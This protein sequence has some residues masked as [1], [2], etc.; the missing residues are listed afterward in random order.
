MQK[1]SGETELAQKR[2]MI[3]THVHEF[4][5]VHFPLPLSYLA[6]PDIGTLRRTFQRMQSQ[7]S[8]MSK[9]NAFSPM[10]NATQSMDN[11]YAM[12]QENESLRS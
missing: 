8:Q 5:K 4:E 3:L 12:E 1:P 7:M 11:F 6:E 9:S 2:Y 10:Y